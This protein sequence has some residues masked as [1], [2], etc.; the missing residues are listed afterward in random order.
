M[1]E[2]GTYVVVAE[3]GLTKN[4]YGAEIRHS[5]PLALPAAQALLGSVLN[6]AEPDFY[7]LPAGAMVLAMA[8]GEQYLVIEDRALQPKKLSR[9]TLAQVRT[10]PTG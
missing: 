8:S 4:G 7:Q 9:F 6:G 1:S 10:M 3:L 5:V 2:G